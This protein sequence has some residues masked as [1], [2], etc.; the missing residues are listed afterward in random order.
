MKK[1]LQ[2]WIAQ[3]FGTE[4]AVLLSVFLVASIIIVATLGD[5]L[6]PVIAA[7]IFAFL[8]QGVV[9]NLTK[10]GVSKIAAVLNLLTFLV[11]FITVLVVLIPII[12]RQTSLLLKELPNMVG[13]LKQLLRL[14][15][16]KASEYIE[17]EVIQLVVTRVSE[18]VANLAE[19]LNP[20]Y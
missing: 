13:Q 17:P 20:I 8:L 7:L 9:N 19:Q 2:R 5:V 4:E 3:Y 6:G 16:E 1:V 12:G 15:P 14:S 18:E 11:T 10:Q